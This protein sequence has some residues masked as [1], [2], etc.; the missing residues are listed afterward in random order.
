[1]LLDNPVRKNRRMFKARIV[2]INHLCLNG[3]I[4]LSADVR[5]YHI[6]EQRQRLSPA[7]LGECW[8][9]D[10]PGNNWFC[11]KSVKLNEEKSHNMHSTM[12]NEGRFSGKG[13]SEA[14]WILDWPQVK[15]GTAY[16]KG[17]LCVK[18]LRVQY[19]S[20]LENLSFTSRTFLI[21]MY[22]TLPESCSLLRE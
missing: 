5:W 14:V 9:S 10:G 1:M 12:N 8:S 6:A 3:C 15:L 2:M 19:Y 13:S 22:H 17:S 21:S 16:C 20:F 11:S 4:L 7:Y 18:L